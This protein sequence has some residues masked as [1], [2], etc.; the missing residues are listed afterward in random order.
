MMDILNVLDTR[1]IQYEDL[2]YALGRKYRTSQG[3]WGALAPFSHTGQARR[4]FISRTRAAYKSLR[5][6]AQ[7]PMNIEVAYYEIRILL[8]HPIAQEIEHLSESVKKPKAI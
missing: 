2:V 4:I 6:W 7:E 8:K 5:T 1:I 3:Q